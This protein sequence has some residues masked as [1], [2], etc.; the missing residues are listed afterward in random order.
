M[1]PVQNI[2]GLLNPSKV[3]LKMF[4]DIIKFVCTSAELSHKMLR[5]L[6]QHPTEESR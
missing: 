6:F 3:A 4:V 1:N 5:L 2:D